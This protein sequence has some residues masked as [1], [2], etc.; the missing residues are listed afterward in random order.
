MPA[1]WCS[2]PAIIGA[3]DLVSFCHQVWMPVMEVK[4]ECSAGDSWLTCWLIWA[5]LACAACAWAG[6]EAEASAACAC[7]RAPAR[8]VAGLAAAIPSPAATPTP[9]SP[10]PPAASGAARAGRA[11]SASG[12]AAAISEPLTP[13]G[14]RLLSEGPI[15]DRMLRW[16]LAAPLPPP[17]PPVPVLENIRVS[18]DSTPP[19]RCA[20]VV[21]RWSSCWMDRRAWLAPVSSTCGVSLISWSRFSKSSM[22]FTSARSLR[23][24]SLSSRSSLAIILP[25]SKAMAAHLPAACSPAAPA[26]WSGR[27]RRSRRPPPCA[28]AGRLPRPRGSPPRRRRSRS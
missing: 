24:N 2:G 12:A 16:K 9:A 8:A 18:I 21:I 6:V 23:S 17:V 7:D 26:C 25:A 11:P 15:A 10:T 4:I 14:D 27:S 3:R 20:S 28:P 13:S 19:R 22:R 1:I 5:S